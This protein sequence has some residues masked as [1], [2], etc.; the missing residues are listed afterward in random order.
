MQKVASRSVKYLRKPNCGNPLLS[1]CPK[2]FFKVKHSG[3]ESKA[4]RIQCIQRSLYV[5]ANF[6]P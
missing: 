3:T 2:I 6:F 5:Y 4:F 1:T